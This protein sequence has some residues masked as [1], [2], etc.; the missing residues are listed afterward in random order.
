MLNRLE[1]KDR[2]ELEDEVEKRRCEKSYYEFFKR[3]W[4]ELEPHTPLKDNWHI[5]YLCN[6]LQVEV[7]R[8]V[9]RELKTTD[10]IVN[11][12]P[13]SAK[14]YIHSIT[15]C[16]WAWTRFPHLKFI[17]SSHSKDLAID[18][19]VEG[20]DLINS[21]WYQGHWGE[22][23]QLSSDQN[24]KSHYKN[25]KGGRRMAFSV[26]SPPT[27]KGADIIVADD[28]LD[29][30]KAESDTERQNANR[31]FDDTLSNRLN[32][33][34]TGLI[35]VV[36]QRL[37]EDDVTGHILK[38]SS[39]SYRKICLPAEYDEEV[40]NPPKL[41]KYY[42]DGLFFKERFSLRFLKKLKEKMSSR[43]MAGQY[44]QRPAAAEGNIFKREWWQ[45]Y[46][47]HELPD[48]LENQALSWDLSFKEK[49][50]NDWV[51]GLAGA[52]KDGKLYVLGRLK[53]HMG[54][55]ET[56]KAIV[57]LMSLYPKAKR[58]WVE[59]KANGPAVLDVLKRHFPG[60][61]AVNPKGSKTERAHAVTYIVESGN[62]FLPHPDEAPWVEDF[63]NELSSFPNATHDD[64]VDA[65]TQ[66]LSQ[67]YDKR[68]EE[69]RKLKEAM[70]GSIFLR[71]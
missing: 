65:F 48:D 37:H 59:D 66:L 12:P 1:I 41:K 28:L 24:V 35:I 51:V 43:A 29:P 23:F 32:D 45:F 42:K 18:H 30:E 34:E 53:R 13:R 16:P 71:G 61:I 58:V 54:L 50:H 38:K 25:N 44:Q 70:D 36:M 33:Q 57:E 11:I 26:G 27:G 19:C 67:F 5:K 21:D 3:S 55:S 39:D 17:N 64:Q 2:L 6:I 31:H 69:L 10:L 68:V 40:I 62:V 9:R 22:I 60:M 20:R 15:L 56:L 63:I 8:I 46:R 49:S 14:S 52:K 7:E 47:R 4:Q